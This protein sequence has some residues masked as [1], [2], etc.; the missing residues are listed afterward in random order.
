MLNIKKHLTGRNPCEMFFSW[1]F[2]LVMLIKFIDYL[3]VWWYTTIDNKK[4]TY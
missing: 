4:L 1:Q 3:V 2:V